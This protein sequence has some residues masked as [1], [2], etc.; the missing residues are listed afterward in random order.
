[1]VKLEA[2]V[3][4]FLIALGGGLG[5]YGLGKPLPIRTIHCRNFFPALIRI[6]QG[7]D[8]ASRQMLYR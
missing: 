7:P 3:V 5:L 2:F 6:C 8:P 1:M 4:I